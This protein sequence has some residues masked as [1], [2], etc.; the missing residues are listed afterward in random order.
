MLE[1]PSLFF[2]G[3]AGTRLPIAVA[4]GEGYAN[5]ARQGDAT[6]ALATGRTGE[7][8]H[9]YADHGMV[10]AAETRE[11][12]RAELIVTAITAPQGLTGLWREQLARARRRPP[13]PVA[14]VA[15]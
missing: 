8:I 14:E 9:A 4:H 1:S 15:T 12:A 13:A 6:R 10:H 7:A 11:A 3:M 2:H 5:F